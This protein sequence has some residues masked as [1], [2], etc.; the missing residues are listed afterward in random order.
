M[1]FSFV[2]D[3][4]TEGANGKV[5]CFINKRRVVVFEINAHS[6]CGL[7]QFLSILKVDPARTDAEAAPPIE[8]EDVLADLLIVTLDVECWVVAVIDGIEGIPVGVAQVKVAIEGT[9]DEYSLNRV[10]VVVLN[11]VFLVGRGKIIA[12]AGGAGGL[13]VSCNS[14]A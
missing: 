10:D 8:R 13:E 4:Q 7:D 5:V 14:W 6:A 2:A 3:F 9:I 12:G 1:W 11:I